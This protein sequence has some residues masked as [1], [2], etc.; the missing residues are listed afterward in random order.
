MDSETKTAP[1]LVLG[2][3]GH[4]GR[5]IVRSLLARQA[6]VRVLSRNGSSARRALGAGPEILEGD[7]TSRQAVAQ[8]LRGAR[9]V[10]V[11]LSAF[12]PQLIRQLERIERDGVLRVFEEARAVGLSRIVYLSAYELRPA[13]I[14][15]L[16]LAFGRVKLAVETALAKSN[17][18]WTV[19]GVAVSMEIF[20]ATIRGK[21]MMVPGGGPPALPT[22]SALDVGEIAAQVALREDLGGQRIRVTGPEALSFREA[23][24][25]ISAVRGKPLSYQKVPLLPLQV[26]ASLTRPVNPYLRHLLASVRLMKCFP[27]DLAA[28]VPQDHQRLLDRFD[29]APTTL[30]MEAR[31]RIQIDGGH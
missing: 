1:I 30:E 26:A 27:Q 24:R 25:R 17:L 29:Y 10:V 11:S 31:N 6:P 28:E 23:A 19:L 22:V 20:F 18:N 2:G 8:A 13:L 3:T 5:Q 4:Y 21:R 7:I 9:A 14:E 16:D 12:S 15:E